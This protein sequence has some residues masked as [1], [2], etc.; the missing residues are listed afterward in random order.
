MHA[1][2]SLAD[3]QEDLADSWDDR[4]ARSSKVSK[5]MAAARLGSKLRSKIKQNKQSEAT[6]ARAAAEAARVAAEAAKRAEVAAR[7]TAAAAA[8]TVEDGS[9]EQYAQIAAAAAATAPAAGAT[10][11][12]SAD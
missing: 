8:S 3:P 11:S 9:V 12:K 5:V 1:L 7:E 4:W 10:T 2:L 6:A